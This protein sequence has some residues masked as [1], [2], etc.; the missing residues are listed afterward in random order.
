MQWQKVEKKHDRFGQFSPDHASAPIILV[1]KALEGLKMP[2]YETYCFEAGQTN[3]LLGTPQDIR[4]YFH[5]RH[6]LSWMCTRTRH[7][8]IKEDFLTLAALLDI[9]PLAWRTED[10]DHK[11]AQGGDVCH[12]LDQFCTWLHETTDAPPALA[13]ESVH[14]LMFIHPFRE[15]M[16]LFMRWVLSLIL[17]H[18][19]YPPPLLSEHLSFAREE[20]AEAV[21]KGLDA[22][23]SLIPPTPPERQVSAPKPVILKRK[24][25]IKASAPKTTGDYVKIGILATQ[26]NETVPTLRYWT[27]EGLINAA[28]ITKSGYH[29]YDAETFARIEKIQGMKRKRFTLREIKDAL[30]QGASTPMQE[31][32]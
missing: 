22:A 14:A 32:R 6:I 23:L 9:T 17:V 5:R 13:A 12:M 25:S 8:L 19:G 2:L 30:A 29:L 16:D 7:P 31:Q 28:H 27:K 3:V 1:Q 4:A 20:I 18:R 15:K 24:K 10:L 21:T 11:V 26:V